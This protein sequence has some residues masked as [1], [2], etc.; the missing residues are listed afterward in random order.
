MPE[1]FTIPALPSVRLPKATDPPIEMV[2]GLASGS[3]VIALRIS[4]AW[5]KTSVTFET[6]KVA[7]SCAP[8]GTVA[9][10][11]LAAVFQS[12]LV[13]LRFHVALPARL[14]PTLKVTRTA[15]RTALW[16]SF[17]LYIDG[18][19]RL[20]HLAIKAW[21]YTIRRLGCGRRPAA[22]PLHATVTRRR[23]HRR[24]WPSSIHVHGV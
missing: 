8:F 14:I 22:S 9:G 20:Q 12:L 23:F 18:K 24:H 10:V 13:G 15:D 1:L 5:T 11:Q 19:V 21:D 4:V 3:K 16:I 6:S 2:N 7:V 17:R